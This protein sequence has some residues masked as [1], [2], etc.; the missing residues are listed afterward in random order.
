MHKI[1]YRST[2]WHFDIL[3]W[4]IHK[5]PIESV[6]NSDI[7]LFNLH[8]LTDQI[9]CNSIGFLFFLTSCLLNDC[10]ILFDQSIITPHC[11]DNRSRQNNKSTGETLQINVVYTEL[12]LLIWKRLNSLTWTQGETESQ[13]SMVD[14]HLPKKSGNFGWNANGRLLL[15]PRTENF[16]GKQDFL[17]GK[18]ANFPNGISEWKVCVHSLVFT[19]SRP[20]YLD[21]LWSFL[22]GKSLKNGTSA[23]LW[24][25]PFA[26]WPVL[27][28]KTVDQSVFRGNGKQPTVCFRGLKGQSWVGDDLFY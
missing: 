27:F 25:F 17:K 23:S 21:R 4:V 6:C 18:T 16:S 13:Q 12:T 11:Q 19:Y 7:Q 24:R 3:I 2:F 26:I 1:L 9:C 15:S 22:S 5:P 14:Y 20:L 28:I 8:F 10:I